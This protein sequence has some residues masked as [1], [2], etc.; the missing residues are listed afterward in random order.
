ML[1]FCLSNGS[2]TSPNPSIYSLLVFMFFSLEREVVIEPYISFCV[3]FENKCNSAR[4]QIPKLGKKWTSFFTLS[5]WVE[6]FK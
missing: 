6:W 2:N 3:L 1:V 5:L 4:R